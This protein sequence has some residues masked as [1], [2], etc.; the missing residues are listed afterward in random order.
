M[1]EALKQIKIALRLLL[2]LT[3]LTGLIYPAIVTGLAHILF[4]WQTNG[5]FI[6]VNDKA[7]GS[8]LIG[9]SFTDAKY[10]WGRPSATVPFP[11]NA[12]ASSGSN[13]GPSNPN[14]LSLIKTRITN[15]QKTNPQDQGQN[16]VPVDL[17]TASGSGLDPE[18]SPRAVFYQISRVA[19][20]RN[21]PEEKI[22]AL[23][24]NKIKKRTF[25]ILGEPR[26]NILELNLALDKI[27]VSQ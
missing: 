1:V 24:K 22:Y 2:I 4:P 15:L 19:K 5:S 11:Y 16:A 20:A 12:Q 17:V 6:I 3:I 8:L 27:A 23:V 14:F 9:Q 21:L 10:F 26:V 7:V 25:G 13:L 18:L